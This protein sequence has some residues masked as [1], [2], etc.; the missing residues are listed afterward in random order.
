MESGFGMARIS[1]SVFADNTSP[2]LRTA[3]AVVLALASTGCQ[4]PQGA[5]GNTSSLTPPGPVSS[6]VNLT[7]GGQDKDKNAQQSSNDTDI[8]GTDWYRQNTDNDLQCEETDNDCQAALAAAALGPGG[9]NDADRPFASGDNPGRG[10]GQ[11]ELEARRR[12]AAQQRMTELRTQLAAAQERLRLL[13]QESICGNGP[14][15]P[16]EA[17]N[18]RRRQQVPG[19]QAEIDRIQA[20]MRDIAASL[21]SAA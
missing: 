19:V 16:C 5:N 17:A 10:D 9:T 13:S 4:L 7:Q 1:R 6:L 8:L 3:L 21:G 20:E 2:L 12:H 14:T 11:A 15:A 18:E